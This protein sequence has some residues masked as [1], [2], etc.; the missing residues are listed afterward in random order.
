MQKAVFNSRNWLLGKQL[1]D[2]QSAA[3]E[4]WQAICVSL[5]NHETIF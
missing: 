4:V 2:F 3:R 5:E 1:R